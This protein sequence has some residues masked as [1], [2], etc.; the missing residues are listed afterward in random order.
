MMT[1][2]IVAIH[3][4][5]T[6]TAPMACRTSNSA[7]PRHT[8][9]TLTLESL[10]LHPSTSRPMYR[11]DTHELFLRLHWKHR[12]FLCL[13]WIFLRLARTVDKLAQQRYT[14]YQSQI[15]AIFLFYDYV[16]NHNHYV[17]G[18]NFCP[19]RTRYATN[20]E[21]TNYAA[22]SH[23]NRSTCS[24]AKYEASCKSFFML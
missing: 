6:N 21:R 23:K 1:T 19:L 12:L 13:R 14:G 22:S 24:T 5:D 10:S 17:P 2:P 16:G 18:T 4:T 15:P 8:F 20:R 9:S 11:G 7:L 3:T